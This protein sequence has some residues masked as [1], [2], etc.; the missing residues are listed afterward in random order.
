[1]REIAIRLARAT[2]GG[3]AYWLELPISELLEYLIELG[4]QLREENAAAE[5]G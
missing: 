3:V 5:G 4:D 2:G 1:L